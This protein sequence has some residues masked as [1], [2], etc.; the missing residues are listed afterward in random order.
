MGITSIVR[1][2]FAGP[3]R[4][5]GSDPTAGRL[6]RYRSS[7][8]MVERSPAAA[9]RSLHRRAR[10]LT[11]RSRP[12]VMAGCG[13]RS[14]IAND[15]EGLDEH[16]AGHHT[17]RDRTTARQRLDHRL[18]RSRPRLRRRPVPRVGRPARAVPDRTHRAMGRVVAPDALRRRATLRA[19]PP[20]VQ[21][22]RRRRAD[23][24]RRGATAAA[25]RDPAATDRLRTSPITPGHAG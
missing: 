24:H 13:R 2:Y 22:Q 5:R 21:L 8:A 12:S 9:R 25:R 23:V 17:T 16:R 20:R 14:R 6:E 4:R 11:R 7:T 3:P 1:S 15:M 19:G 18:R 10:R